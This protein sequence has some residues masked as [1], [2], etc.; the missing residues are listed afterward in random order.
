[1][2]RRSLILLLALLPVAA[3]AGGPSLAGKVSLFRRGEDGSRE[4]A[5]D[6]SEVLVYVTGFEAP[7]PGGLAPRMEQRDKAFIPAVLPVVKGQSVEFVNM[8]A[9]LHNVFSPSPAAAAPG[10][11]MDLG[12]YK[13]PGRVVSYEFKRTGLVDLYCDI[14]ESM[15][16]TVVV[17]PNPVFTFAR[18]D[19]SFEFPRDLGSRQAAQALEAHLQQA[20]RIKVFAWAK[21]A[22][23]P[24]SVELEVKPGVALPPLVME[25]EMQPERGTHDDKHGRP[26]STH[27]PGYGE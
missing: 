17:L 14:H 15:R 9:L 12:K 11:K 22:R 4:R 3:A 21:G 24:A 26:Y 20:G 2:G 10:R 7:A 23:A 27:P 1:V 19:G 6:A 25:L 16:A 13:G 5:Q 8:D 18:R